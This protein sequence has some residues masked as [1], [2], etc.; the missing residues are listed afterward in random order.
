MHSK[1]QKFCRKY[2]KNI[3]EHNIKNASDD[4]ESPLC[5]F[6]THAVTL[7]N[8]ILFLDEIFDI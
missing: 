4:R 1:G 8:L 3:C 6:Y 5:I 7:E 2:K